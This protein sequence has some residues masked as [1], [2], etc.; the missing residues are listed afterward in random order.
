MLTEREHKGGMYM[1]A[2]L[3]LDDDDISKSDQDNEYFP[4]TE[5]SE[6]AVRVAKNQLIWV[7]QMQWLFMPNVYFMGI[8][9]IRI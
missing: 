1:Y 3:I 6:F 9:L 7:I 5:E 4:K 2:Q 8:I